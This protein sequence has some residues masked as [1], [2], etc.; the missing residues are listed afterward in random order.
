M[1]HLAVAKEAWPLIVA[2]AV[3]GFLAYLGGAYVLVVAISIAFFLAVWVFRE[4][5]GESPKQPLAILAPLT[6][7]VTD[8]T[9]AYDPRL[10][11][12][13]TTIEIRKAWNSPLRLFAPTEGKVDGLR[14]VEEQNH[15]EFQVTTDEGESVLIRLYRRWY[16]RVR[17]SF[18]QGERVGHG[19][20]IG[21]V[22]GVY[23]LDLSVAEIAG[24]DV[25]VGD[26]AIAPQTV[27]ATF[28]RD[29]PAVNLNT[30]SLQDEK[31]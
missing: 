5:P 4:P 19:R 10:E 22:T 15:I 20:A 28:G 29:A 8:I 3:A 24:V 26:L 18:A 21:L 12:M 16:S 23:K 7:N 11:A 13:A 2:L 17:L 25:A 27:L 30:V 31:T 1:K 9:S 14:V 6:G